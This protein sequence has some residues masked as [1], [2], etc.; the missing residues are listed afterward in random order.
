MQEPLTLF[1]RVARA[2][3]RRS[4]AEFIGLA[5]YNLRLMLTG[6][7]KQHR[8]VY[9]RSFDK[10]YNVDT[11]GTEE[12]EFLSASDAALKEHGRRYEAVSPEMF[13]GMLAHLDI[14]RFEDFTFVDIGSG[15]GRALFLAAE[16]PF[17]KII[18]VEFARELHETAEK[19]IATYSNPAQKCRALQ[20]VCGDG[21]TFPMP[22]GPVLCFINNPFGEPLMRKLADHLVAD[23]MRSPRP[24]FLAYLH[25]NH[26]RVFA[27]EPRWKLLATGIVGTK[28]PYWIARWTPA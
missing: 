25:A 18:G 12:L 11:A 9:D 15:K 22:A 23:L 5:I 1:G 13:A 3:Q 7:T 19:N 17:K 16:Y 8:Y 6:G 20:S 2:W 14:G 4:L 28:A 10:K 27:S 26:A 21:A 24:F